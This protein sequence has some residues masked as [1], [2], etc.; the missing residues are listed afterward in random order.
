MSGDA[1]NVDPASLRGEAVDN[2]FILK[3]GLA[4]LAVVFSNLV[5]GFSYEDWES[6]KNNLVGIRNLLSDK[7]GF[8][9]MGIMLTFTAACHYEIYFMEGNKKHKRDGRR[10]HCKVTK[11][12]T[13]GTDMLIGPNC[14]LRAMEIL[15]VEGAPADQVE[16]AFE[17]AAD[18]CAA[19]RC[20]LLEA[21]AN[22]RLA[23]L[24]R[25]EESNAG[26]CV[27]YLNRAV[28]L[29][30][31]WGAAAKAEWL[32]KQYASILSSQM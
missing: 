28:G 29:Y 3:F 12:A 27:K 4:T 17:K 5:L 8:F 9:G 21:L 18:A 6:T 22:E 11:W 1:R 7:N 26:K 10:V 13:T 16:I 14:F 30:R 23:R 19:Q 24:F 2:G 15:C 20:R 32:E 25:S 31:T